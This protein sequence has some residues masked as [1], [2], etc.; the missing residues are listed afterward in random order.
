MVLNTVAAITACVSNSEV[1]FEAIAQ[2]AAD[3]HG[4][5][6]RFELV[7]EAGGVTVMDDY[8]HHPTEVR[9]TIAAARARFSPRRIFGVY[10]PHT[11]S[12]IAYLWDDW[13]RCWDGLDGLVVLETYA[14]REEP[15]PGRSAADLAAAIASPAAVYAQDFDDAARKA[16]QLVRPGDVVFTIGA[17][18]VDTVGPKLLELLR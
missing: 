5:R 8:A 13:A 15:L 17:G 2:A 1:E 10:Q 9:A 14:A 6:R 16:A 11:Y 12:R 7:G 4:A 3:F 18:D